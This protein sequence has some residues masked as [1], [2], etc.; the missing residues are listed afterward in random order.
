MLEYSLVLNVAEKV[1]GLLGDSK[2]DEAIEAIWKG[3]LETY[4]DISQAHFKSARQAVVSAEH[5]RA[6]EQELRHAIAHLRDAFNIYESLLEK[7]KT[8]RLLL[9]IKWEVPVVSDLE[10]DIVCAR[11]AEV[12]AL[13][14]GLYRRIGEPENAG[15]A[16]DLALPHRDPFVRAVLHSL[17]SAKEV[18]RT[19]G[20]QFATRRTDVERIT[21]SPSGYNS[22]EV[23]PELCELTPRGEKYVKERRKEIEL[24]FER[25]FPVS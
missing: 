18:Y 15:K 14:H 12:A 7:K 25:M 22:R 13:M 10:R 20:E 17:Y 6:P 23:I 19:K 21:I 2:T 11:L 1:Y 24:N 5:S 16:R 8:Q 3:L 9:V 4:G